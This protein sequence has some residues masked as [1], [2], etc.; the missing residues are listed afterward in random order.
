[1]CAKHTSFRAFTQCHPSCVPSFLYI[2]RPHPLSNS[3]PHTS[4]N[5][6]ATLGPAVLPDHTDCSHPDPNSVHAACSGRKGHTV[7]R[8]LQS[9]RY[10][11]Q[12]RVQQ[13]K[14]L[15]SSTSYIGLWV[16]VAILWPQSCMGVSIKSPHRNVYRAHVC[17]CVIQC[18]SYIYVYN[19]QLKGMYSCV[20]AR[21]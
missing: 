10:N 5:V 19:H 8:G 20:H 7:L 3:L 13:G 1:M 2:I 4:C 15:S 18:F 14:S 9:L 17:L 11:Q 16:G 12:H 6:Q 21:M